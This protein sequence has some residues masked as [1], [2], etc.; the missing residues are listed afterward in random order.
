MSKTAVFHY[1]W[2]E[3]YDREAQFTIKWNDPEY[4]FFWPTIVNPILSQRDS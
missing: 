4:N 1:K 2:S 3:Y